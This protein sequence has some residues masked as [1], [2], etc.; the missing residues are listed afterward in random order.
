MHNHYYLDN[1]YPELESIFLEEEWDEKYIEFK[2]KSGYADININD[3]T[4]I[5]RKNWVYIIGTIFENGS[6]GEDYPNCYVTQ[7]SSREWLFHIAMEDFDIANNDALY[8][9]VNNSETDIG[10][11]ACYKFYQQPSD[12][13]KNPYFED[14]QIYKGSQIQN[15]DF[16][17]TYTLKDPMK[18]GINASSF[19]IRAWKLTPPVNPITS[20]PQGTA[21]RIYD[22]GQFQENGDGE[23]IVVSN[24]E[25]IIKFTTKDIPF[26]DGDVLFFKTYAQ[27]SIGK[28]T[29][30]SWGNGIYG[31]YYISGDPPDDDESP[32]YIDEIS[33]KNN[34]ICPKN[35]KV[36]FHIKDDISGV[37]I[38]S[39]YIWMKINDGADIIVYKNGQYSSD[40]DGTVEKISDND[41]KF[42]CSYKYNF[43]FSS[44]VVFYVTASDL[45]G[46]GTE[47]PE[48]FAFYIEDICKKD[49]NIFI[50]MLNRIMPSNYI[51]S[52]T[53]GNGLEI[54]R[55]GSHVFARFMEAVCHLY[56]GNLITTASGG[57]HSV[58]YVTLSRTNSS[59][60]EIAIKAG[61]LFKTK[62]GI[63]FQ[64][65]QDVILGETDLEIDIPVQSL[66]CSYQ[67]NV[68]ENE[69]NIIT[70]LYTDNSINSELYSVTNKYATKFGTADCLYELGQNRG[71]LRGTYEPINSFR[72]RLRQLGHAIT[73]VNIEKYIKYILKHY[74]KT[75]YVKEHF[76]IKFFYDTGKTPYD[77]DLSD[78]LVVYFS[79]ILFNKAFTIQMPRFPIAPHGFIYDSGLSGYDA[80]E[81]YDGGDL[82]KIAFL[83]SVHQQINKIK[84]AGINFKIQFI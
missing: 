67:A 84:A 47:S 38:E 9:I 4:I 23:I 3:F 79:T 8:F 65:T 34:S 26:R 20:E 78:D 27:N 68:L 44:K 66:L 73:K 30:A 63:E 16:L 75:G 32:P 31:L 1:F 15:G 62:Y 5:V 13:P 14:Y 22:S 24:Y 48:Y 74:A 70:K 2:L 28:P 40:F 6:F 72:T 80:G 58:G 52:L 45:N 57:S 12:W 60:G 54:F 17:I 49:P 56:Y 41:Y 36:E 81:S 64:S 61:S 19:I 33:P 10:M 55:G 50:E 11:L 71:L 7:I 43:K 82:G 18:L 53:D 35:Q 83:R 76:S 69:I 39:V 21:Y 46:N 77:L 37:D 59:D 25:Y 29:E 42:S 51:D